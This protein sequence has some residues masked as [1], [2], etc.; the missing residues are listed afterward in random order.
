M[1]LLREGASRA[2]LDLS[3]QTLETLGCY[4]ELLLKWNA[5]VNLTAAKTRSEILQRHILDSLCI[6]PAFEKYLGGAAR[7]LDVGS[8]GGLPGVV[9]A[10]VLPACTITLV[11][12]VGKKCAFLRQAALELGLANVRVVNARVES[13]PAMEVDAVTS[14]GFATLAETVRLTEPVV[15][16]SCLWLSMKG[17]YPEEEIGELPEDCIVRESVRVEVPFLNE[18]RHLVVLQFKTS[19]KP[20]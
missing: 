17:K 6:V 9:L 13:L 19:E 12:S 2:G 16:R 5:V 7:V 8:G 18:E 4:A 10:T 1:T 14:R 3:K 20:A 11:D 15:G